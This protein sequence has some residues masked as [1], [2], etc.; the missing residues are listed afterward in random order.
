[1]NF[2][3]LTAIAIVAMLT[4]PMALASVDADESSGFDITDGMGDTFHFDGPAER[5]VSSG[6]GATLT[7]IDAGQKDKIVAAD[8]YSFYENK[9]DEKLIGLEATNLGS[10]YGT[11]SD[12][13]ILTELVNM[14]DEYKTL[15]KDDPII[16]IN[17]DDN[18]SLRD[19]LRENGF[20]KVLMWGEASSYQTVMDIV[21]DVSMIVTGTEPE[22]VLSMEQTIADI[23]SGVSEIPESERTDALFVW[24]YS[25]Q[26]TIGSE[27][28]M[29]SMIELCGGK[30]LG[31]REGVD[32]W[33]S[34]AEIVNILESNPDAV[35][36]VNDTYFSSGKTIQD[37]RD[38]V[39]GGDQSIR[40]VA[41][42]S[43]WN[44]CCPE[45]VDGLVAVSQCL[46]P[47]IFGEYDTGEESGDDG[48][49]FPITYVA[50][51]IIVVI[52]IVAVAVVLMRR[53]P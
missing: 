48:S 22:S 25:K 47:E 15:Q 2:K 31:Y 3:M 20:T 28:I 42:D 10:F 9:N 41:M 32:R 7:I 12:G 21:R 34:S 30:N 24:Y 46:Y 51:G 18:L 23:Q 50:I 19:L 1:M 8:K 40:V 27:S 52:A 37:F 45:S 33:G 43:Q 29:G 16:L 35:V 26:F 36:F 13:A 53:K 39:L 6:Y 11:T 4:V 17:Y 49:D 14:V 5:I 44:N 38:E